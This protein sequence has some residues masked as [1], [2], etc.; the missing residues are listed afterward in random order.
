MVL[1][2]LVPV[3]VD[4]L[5][6]ML[7]LRPGLRISAAGALG[8]LWLQRSRVPSPHH[9]SIELVELQCERAE[10]QN[11][12]VIPITSLRLHAVLRLAD[13][14]HTPMSKKKSL[15]PTKENLCRF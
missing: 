12:P 15:R 14:V 10:L 13:A 6:R 7:Q 4:F 8:H 11:M 3:G 2:Q 1:P 5:Q 9:A